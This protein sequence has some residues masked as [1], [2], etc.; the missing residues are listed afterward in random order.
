[1]SFLW[2]KFSCLLCKLL[3]KK[4]K[5][6]LW[7]FRGQKNPPKKIV[8]N[9]CR[10][11][12]SWCTSGHDGDSRKVLILEKDTPQKKTCNSVE[13]GLCNFLHF[14]HDIYIYMYIIS[15][16]IF[17]INLTGTPLFQKRFSNFNKKVFDFCLYKKCVFLLGGL[18]SWMVKNPIFCCEKMG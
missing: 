1:M 5:R 12:K 17:F 15:I 9:L 2:C 10:S 8:S 11:T 16:H 18:T 6:N 7:A 4:K 3:F 14:F 13:L